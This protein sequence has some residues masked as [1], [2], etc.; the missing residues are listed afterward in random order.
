LSRLRELETLF[1]ACLAADEAGRRHL[2][3]AAEPA[4]ADE[5]RRLLAADARADARLASALSAAAA[6]VVERVERAAETDAIGRRIGPYELLEELGRGGMSTVYRAARVDDAFDQTVAVKLVRYGLATPSLGRRLVAERRILAR[7]QHPNIARLLDGG[8]TEDAAPYFVMEAIDGRPIDLDCDLR[9][10]GVDDRLRLFRTVCRAVTYAHRNLVV[11]RDLK[12]SNV[13]VKADGEPMLLDFGIAKLLDP[14]AEGETTL[15]LVRLGTPGFASPEQVLGEPIT[16]A[17]DI[18]SLGVLLY[19]LLVGTRPY[20][21]AET[22]PVREV[23]AA[24]V[25]QAPMV[26]SVAARAVPAEVAARRGLRPESLARRLAGD[27]DTI[28]LTA[29]RKEPERRYGSVQQLSDDIGRHLS[30]HPVEARPDTFGYRAGKF[31]RRH[32]WQTATALVALVVAG[33]FVAALVRQQAR[34]ERQRARAEAVSSMLVSLFELAGPTAERGATLTARELLDRGREELGRLDEQ[35]ATQALLR[36]TLGGLYERLG[37]FGEA[38]ELFAE[39]LEQR[40]RL[41]GE[42]HPAVAESL[43]HLGRATALDGELAAAEPLFRRALELRRALLGPEHPDV[44]VSLNSLALVLHEQGAYDEAEPLYRQALERAGRLLGADDAQTVKTRANLALLQLD[45]GE[46]ADAEALFRRALD[47]WRTL[48]GADELR[49]EVLD[50]LARTLTARGRLDEAEVRAREALALRRRL[51]DERHPVR[52]R[53]LAHLGDI[54][55]RRDPSAA[56]PLIAE[57]LARRRERLGEDNAETAESLAIL[58]ALRADQGRLDEAE[59]L[60]RRAIATY[61][62]AL[63]PRHPMGAPPLLA[64]GRLLATR[65]ECSSARPWLEQAAAL[66]PAADRPS[67]IGA[68]ARCD[69]DS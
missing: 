42:R 19:H 8:T 43:Y 47:G 41:H 52:A 16:T 2:L 21:V 58:A 31:V 13:L 26:P 6:G 22:A 51:Y 18:Y 32:R 14:S 36:D 11:H 67:A 23:E 39:A 53:D 60:Y 50:G 45:R 27:L 62:R 35:P 34:A 40:R 10:L 68:L 38:R 64:L 44:A 1:A 28:L 33:L 29:L 46:L 25:E 54:V 37:L 57:A 48:T 9:R 59:D 49:A 3:E 61:R 24:I 55:R 65:G 4:L 20:R 66:L 63:G 12:P 30:G 56:E 17:S 69:G 5:V 15:S 7:L